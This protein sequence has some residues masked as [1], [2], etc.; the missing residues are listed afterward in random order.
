[1]GLDFFKKSHKVINMIAK[2]INRENLL[3]LFGECDLIKL[4]G[5][6]VQPFHNLRGEIVLIDYAGNKTVMGD[7][8]VYELWYSETTTFVKTIFGDIY[9]YR[10]VGLPVEIVQKNS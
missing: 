8:V 1:M 7:S 4:K 3:K 9:L 5:V 6:I 10:L 2:K